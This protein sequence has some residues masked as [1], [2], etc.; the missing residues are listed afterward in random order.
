MHEARAVLIWGTGCLLLVGCSSRP[1]RVK[2]VDIDPSSASSAAIEMHDKDG[3]DAIGGAELDA[4]PGLKKHVARYDRDSDGK[5]SQD[6]IYQRLADWGKQKLAFMGASFIVSLDGQPLEGATLT[7][8]PEGYLGENVKPAT[9][10]TGPTGLGRLAHADE[11]LPKTTNGRPMHGVFGGTYK[12]QITHPSRNIP[13]K[14]NTATVLGEEI[15]YD[16]NPTDA[17]VRL[18]LTSN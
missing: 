10:V 7:M 8:V 17:P 13:A 18:A 11:F 16:I 9:G 6:E 3:D 2:P 4:V 14:Y 1:A 15:A 5:I 12:V